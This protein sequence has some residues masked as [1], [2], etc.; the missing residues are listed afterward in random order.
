MS[1][2]RKGRAGGQ[3]EQYWYLDQSLTVEEVEATYQGYLK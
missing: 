3:T 1:L 2:L